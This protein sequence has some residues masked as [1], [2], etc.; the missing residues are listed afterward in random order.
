MVDTKRCCERLGYESGVD[1]WG[2]M[3]SVVDISLFCADRQWYVIS[4]YMQRIGK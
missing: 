2:I 3:D 1:R 4:V